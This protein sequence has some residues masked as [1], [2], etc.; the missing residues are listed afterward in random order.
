MRR[1]PARPAGLS[2]LFLSVL[3]LLLPGAVGFG[4]PTLGGD[5]N[6]VD[7]LNP[8]TLV[9]GHAPAANDEVVIDKKGADDT[10]YKVGDTATVLLS[11]PTQQVKIAGIAKFGK[12]DSPAGARP[13]GSCR[14]DR[15]GQ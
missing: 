5:W 3:L 1:S 12:A 10:G 13:R 8:W 15:V 2:L 4:P 9:A 14:S 7:V 11:G 6:S